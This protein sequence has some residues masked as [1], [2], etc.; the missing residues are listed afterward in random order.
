MRPFD[1]EYDI[2]TLCFMTAAE[3]Q[4]QRSFSGQYAAA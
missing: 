2:I 4:W 1:V 3:L